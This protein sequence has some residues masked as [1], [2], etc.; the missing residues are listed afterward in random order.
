M[1]TTPVSHLFSAIYRGPISR[2]IIGMGPPAFFG[3]G[4][5]PLI[6]RQDDFLECGILQG[7]RD[8]FCVYFGSYLTWSKEK[9]GEQSRTEVTVVTETHPPFL[10]IWGWARILHSTSRVEGAPS[11]Q[12]TILV[13]HSE[14]TTALKNVM[15]R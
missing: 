8:R 10:S 1:P 6:L 7:P 4:R 14:K 11:A 3:G 15:C 9:P 2:F 12:F 5:M 13:I